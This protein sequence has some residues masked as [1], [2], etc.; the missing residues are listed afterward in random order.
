MRTHNQILLSSCPSYGK[1]INQSN[2][3][4][5]KF[6][7]PVS[8]SSKQEFVMVINTISNRIRIKKKLITEIKSID[9]I[10]L[11]VCMKR[12]LNELQGQDQS[13]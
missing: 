5:S 13:S 12:I 9:V 1:Y 3:L 4:E 2:A 8:F 7:K 6:N 11:M 10:N